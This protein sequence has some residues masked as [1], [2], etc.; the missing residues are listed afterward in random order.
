LAAV[1]LCIIIVL[2]ENFL[3]LNIFPLRN[4]PNLMLSLLRNF[5]FFLRIFF[6]KAY[7]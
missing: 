1:K 2:A 5:L 3:Q 4:W 6:T 7:R